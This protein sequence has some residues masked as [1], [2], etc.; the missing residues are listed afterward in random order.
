MAPVRFLMGLRWRQL[1]LVVCIWMFDQGWIETS[2]F[3]LNDW[4]GLLTSVFLG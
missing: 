3:F 1:L 4:I 2:C